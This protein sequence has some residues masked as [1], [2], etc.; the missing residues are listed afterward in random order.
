MKT[1]I[2]IYSLAVVVWSVKLVLMHL[3]YCAFLL[4]NENLD[5]SSIARP[6]VYLTMYIIYHDMYLFTSDM[7][8]IK[9]NA[10]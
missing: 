1:E 10:L 4:F 7:H 9:C 8:S 3:I 5:V 6:V 2:K